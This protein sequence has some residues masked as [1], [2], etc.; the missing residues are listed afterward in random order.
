MVPAPTVG[1]FFESFSDFSIGAKDL[2]SGSATNMLIRPSADLARESRVSVPVNK[3]P[4]LSLLF[5]DD[6]VDLGLK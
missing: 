2:L 5:P 4:G 3:A 6:T 1:D